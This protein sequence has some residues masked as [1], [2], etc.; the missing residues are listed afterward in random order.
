M[1]YLTTT[2]RTTGNSTMN[3]ESGSSNNR[4]STD[5]NDIQPTQSPNSRSANSSRR[6]S[7]SS[8]IEQPR[9]KIHKSDANDLKHITKLIRETNFIITQADQLEQITTNLTFKQYLLEARTEI[10]AKYQPTTPIDIIELATNILAKNKE[11]MA[12]KY[13]TTSEAKTPTTPPT[14]RKVAIVPHPTLKLATKDNTK[15]KATHHHYPGFYSDTVLPPCE[16]TVEI[17]VKG[18][19]KKIIGHP[20]NSTVNYGFSGSDTI[21]TVQP[22]IMVPK[23]TIED[24]PQ[25]SIVTNYEGK[26]AVSMITGKIDMGAYDAYP[27][28]NGFRETNIH[29]NTRVTRMVKTKPILYA[30]K[31]FDTKQQLTEYLS[32]LEPKPDTFK[33]TLVTDVHN[34]NTQLVLHSRGH[35]IANIHLRHR[36]CDKYATELPEYIPYVEDTTHH[37]GF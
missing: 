20:R 35:M 24:I 19:Q 21:I 18:Q 36:L 1:K 32:T 33:A 17:E 23:E 3:T 30:D 12:R 22:T 11:R 25:G 27:I 15:L 16:R 5:N 6:N 37:S 8:R 2:Q 34:K 26:Q 29:L 10:M 9:K 13:A 14:K 7:T 4:H 31:Q 28:Q